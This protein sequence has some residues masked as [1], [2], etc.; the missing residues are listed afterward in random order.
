MMDRKGHSRRFSD[1]LLS[2]AGLRVVLWAIAAHAFLPDVLSADPFKLTSYHDDHYCYQLENAARETI[3]RYHELPT[4]NPYYCG[5]IPGIANPQDGS[6]APDFLLRIAF[7]EGPGR[8]LAVLLFVMLGMEGLFRLARKHDASVVGA[9]TGA[10][11]F[12]MS[13]EIPVHIRFGWLHFL[14][15]QL[16]PWIA[17]CFESGVTRRGWAVLGGAFLAWIVMCGGTYAAPYAGLLV[18][19]LLVFE[20]AR[21]VVTPR[22]GE[23][24]FSPLVSAAILGLVAIGLS[25]IRT[26]P[27]LRVVFG[28]PRPVSEKEAFDP[29]TLF[30]STWSPQ[31]GASGE[32]YI[33]IGIV[34]LA[35]LA[36][37]LAD[38]AAARF[39]ALALVFGAIAVGQ[40]NDLAPWVFL[41]KLPVYSQLGTPSR[42]MILVLMFLALAGARGL[43]RL[44]DAPTWIA[45][46]ILWRRKRR[47]PI[48]GRLFTGVF[49]A[50]FAGYLGYLATKALVAST[51]INPGTAYA[52]DG[53]LRYADEFRQSRGNRWDSQVWVPAS[54]GSIGCFEESPFFEAAG[55][56]GDRPAEEFASPGSDVAV[57]RVSWSPTRIVLD[58]NAKGPARVLLNQNYDR[59]WT[60]SEGSVAMAP[61]GLL[62]IDLPPGRRK[63]TVAFRDRLVTIGALITIGTLAAI[64]AL[65]ALRISAWAARTPW[66][67]LFLSRHPVEASR[68]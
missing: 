15:Y 66:R 35:L 10:L 68:D 38:R 59:R 46:R 32:Q 11:A 29:L 39:V 53:P 27:L 45:T 13:G 23:R 14:T 44:E 48:L 56:R 63:V 16:F 8:R 64:L 67:A 12:A 58:V 18:A 36:L 60:S 17:L 24:W 30:A 20:T 62:A 28:V 41:H 43:T 6:L 3:V 40:L 2:L 52:M 61:D 51:A 25:A 5:G 34:G 7:G 47:L 33:G 19:T 49:G 57:R 65:V 37:I 9:A 42:I 50:A 4:W 31:F 21:T 54:R 1:R 26:L 22:E 55:L